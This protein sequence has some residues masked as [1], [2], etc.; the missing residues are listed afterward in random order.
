MLVY[1][2][3]KLEVSVIYLIF[4]PLGGLEENRAQGRVQNW[5]EQPQVY[6]LM[7]LGHLGHITLGLNGICGTGHKVPHMFLVVLA[8]AESESATGFELS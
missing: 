7:S 6:R 1:I 4:S 5:R 8:P 3:K 2:I